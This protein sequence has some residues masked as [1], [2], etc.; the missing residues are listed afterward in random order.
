VW[1][2]GRRGKR[3]GG[4]TE[5]SDEEVGEGWSFGE[6][7]NGFA[8]LLQRVVEEVNQKPIRTV[9]HA[10]L[11]ESGVLVD[12]Q[13]SDRVHFRVQLHERWRKASA[14]RH[15]VHHRGGEPATRPEVFRRR[16]GG[17]GTA[18]GSHLRGVLWRQ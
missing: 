17:A 12:V 10:E 15:V 11:V 3:N 13:A 14:D 8:R 9:P 2:R 7:Q 4:L 6:A 5:S 18:R 1:R 16:A